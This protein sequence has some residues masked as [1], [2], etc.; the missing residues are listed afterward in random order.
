MGDTEE[1]LSGTGTNTQDENRNTTSDENSSQSN[2][3]SNRGQWGEI[4]NTVSSASSNTIKMAT[5]STKNKD[6]QK[7]D[8]YVC[9]SARFE[10]R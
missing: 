8:T 1:N 5:M 4:V 6:L 10:I 9:I 2:S 7:R 3:L